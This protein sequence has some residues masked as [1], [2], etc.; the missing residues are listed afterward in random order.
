M[1]TVIADRAEAID[2]AV[3]QAAAQDVILLAGKGHETTQDIGGR[4][5]PFSDIEQAARALDGRANR[6]QERAS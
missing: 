6:V 1:V 5:L 3:R 2:W 4:L